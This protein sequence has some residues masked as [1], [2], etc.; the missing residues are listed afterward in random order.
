MSILFHNILRITEGHTAE[1]VQAVSR[2]VEFVERHGPQ[3][4]VQ[5]FV[6]EQHGLAHSFQVYRD[7]ADV[8][9]HWRMSDPYKQDVMAQCSIDSFEVFGDLS[10]EVRA[11]L[12]SGAIGA[13]ASRPSL[14]GLARS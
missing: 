9:A 10:E 4:A 2:A 3:Q 12:P 8:L 6:D 14:R 7:S 13:R 5:V 11:G 1:F